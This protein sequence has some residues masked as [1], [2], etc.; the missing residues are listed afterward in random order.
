MQRCSGDGPRGSSSSS[1][2]SAQYVTAHGISVGAS[3]REDEISGREGAVVHQTG[4]FEL[5]AGAAEERRR[6]H[7]GGEVGRHARAWRAE[8]VA[9]LQALREQRRLVRR[10]RRVVR[11]VHGAAGRVGRWG[12]CGGWCGGGGWEG[13]LDG[14]VGGDRLGDGTAS[15]REVVSRGGWDGG[16]EG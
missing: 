12:V 9:L 11:A 8:A 7:V 3:G 5:A 1:S 14:A 10:C 15:A 16:C 2:S 4:R 13:R 6:R